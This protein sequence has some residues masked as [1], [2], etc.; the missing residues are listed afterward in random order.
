MYLTN[1]AKHFYI[2]S[3][4]LDFIGKKLLCPLMEDY[5]CVTCKLALPLG[6]C[7]TNQSLGGGTIYYH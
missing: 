3:Y 5:S 1:N 4:I 2:F 6:G 7:H